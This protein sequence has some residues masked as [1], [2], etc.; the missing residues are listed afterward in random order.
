MSASAAPTTPGRVAPGLE[1]G[2]ALGGG[3]LGVV[4][5]IDDDQAVAPEAE[6]GLTQVAGLGQDHA[7]GDGEGDGDGEC[8]TT[9]A[10]RRRPPARPPPGARAEA[11]T[12]A[13]RNRDSTSAGQSPR[14]S[15][16]SP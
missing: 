4:E 2:G 6:V 12:A 16:R 10:S 3:E 15:R 5:G 1:Q 8:S 13:G 7:G 11:S 14:R 9:S